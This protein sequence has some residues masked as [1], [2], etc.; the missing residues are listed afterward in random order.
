[1]AQSFI[2]NTIQ[3]NGNKKGK[4]NEGMTINVNKNVFTNSKFL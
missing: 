1:M 4:E 2:T 3:L